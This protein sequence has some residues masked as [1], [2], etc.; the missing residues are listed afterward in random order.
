[1]YIIGIAFSVLNLSIDLSVCLS[2][3]V[4]PLG[5]INN[6]RETQETCDL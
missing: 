6:F 5:K 3:P 4:C 2:D 1:M